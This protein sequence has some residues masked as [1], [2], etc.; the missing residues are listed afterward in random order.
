MTTWSS[1]CGLRDIYEYI[2]DIL[3][4][5]FHLLQIYMRHV[6]FL[7][8]SKFILDIHINKCIAIHLYNICNE[9]NYAPL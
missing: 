8:I 7:N 4:Q 2:N 3:K 1:W 9:L 5:A 6:V